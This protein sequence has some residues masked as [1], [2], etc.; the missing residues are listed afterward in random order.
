MD[1]DGC[2]FSPERERT[3]IAASSSSVL[4]NT[5]AGAMKSHAEGEPSK[6]GNQNE[7]VALCDRIKELKAKQAAML[8]ERKRITKDLRNHEKRRKRLKAN[9]RRLSDEDLTEVIRIREDTRKHD[10][11]NESTTGCPSKSSGKMGKSS[12]EDDPKK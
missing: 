4:N 8:A 6:S 10:E 7:P 11:G 1:D 5:K 2:A 12:K 3:S 9:A